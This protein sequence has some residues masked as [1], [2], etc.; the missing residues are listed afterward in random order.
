MENDKKAK[1]HEPHNN[2][3]IRRLSNTNPTTTWG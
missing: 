1:Q 3:G 2:M